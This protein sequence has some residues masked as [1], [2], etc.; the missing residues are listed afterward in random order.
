[1]KNLTPEEFDKLKVGDM[2][3]YG[4]DGKGY[5]YYHFIGKIRRIVDVLGFRRIE[6]DITKPISYLPQYIR[7]G[8]GKW[9]YERAWSFPIFR[10]YKDN[11]EKIKAKN[12]TELTFKIKKI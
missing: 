2:I 4:K 7:N 8:E 11:T 6:I 3:E 10:T 5:D 1:M 9:A 12:K